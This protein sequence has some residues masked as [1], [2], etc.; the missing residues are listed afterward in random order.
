MN[1]IS[2]AITLATDTQI[3]SDAGTLFLGNTAT[4]SGGVNLTVA[5]DGNTTFNS[6]LTI[7]TLNKNGNGML[8]LNGGSTYG[9]G[10]FLNSG[11]LNFNNASA[12][13]TGPLVIAGGVIDNTSA[14]AIV[15]ALNNPQNWNADIT[16]LG[17]KD[18]NLGT[19]SVSMNGSRQVTVN[20][21]T[22]TVGGNIDGFG[23]SLT[24]LGPGT[25]VL[26]GSNTY[27]GGTIVSAGNLVFSGSSNASGVTV[28]A[29]TLRFQPTTSATVGAV[30]MTDGTKMTVASFNPNSTVVTATALNLGSLNGA[31][32]N[33][34]LVGNPTTAPLVATAFTTTGTGPNFNVIN[35]STSVGLT[36]GQFPLIS[37]A[38]TIGGNGFSGLTLGTLPL[39]VLASLVNNTANQRVDLNVTGTDTIRWNGTFSSTWDINTTL[40]WKTSST[41]SDTTYLQSSIPG[42]IV[43]FNDAAAA[44][45]NIVIPAPVNPNTVT[46]DNTTHD[47]TF[48]D[49]SITSVSLVK[50]GTG[51]LTFLNDNNFTNIAINAGH[52]VLGNGGT[53]GSLGT[54]SIVLASGATLTVNRSDAVTLGGFSGGGSLIKQGAGTL[55]LTGDYSG[56]T[57]TTTI[58]AGTVILQ[59]PTFTAAN[60]VT[61][62]AGATLDLGGALPADLLNLGAQVVT[63]VGAGVGGN[64]AAVNNGAAQQTNALQHLVLIGDTTIG[65][66]QRWDVRG[67]GSTVTGNFD[68]TKV[69]ANT[70]GFVNA[71][72]TIRDINVN[73]GTVSFSSATV[74]ARNINVNG[75]TL[76]IE[77]GSALDNSNAGT[78]TVNTGG[79]LAFAT[80]GGVDSTVN[81]PI[82]VNDMGVIG[83]TV[84]GTDGSSTVSA[85]ITLN[86][87]GV[88]NPLANA[89]LTLAGPITGTGTFNQ[90]GTGVTMLASTATISY[91]GNTTITAGTLRFGNTN[92][93]PSGTGAATIV[94][95][96]GTL[97][98]NGS[99]Q[100]IDGLTGT[101]VVDTIAG[102]APTLTI[103]GNNSSST[104]LGRYSK[105][106]RDAQSRQDGHRHTHACRHQYVHRHDD[107]QRGHRG[108]AKQ[109]RVRGRRGRRRHG[110]SRR[111]DRSRRHARRQRPEPWREDHQ[112][113]RRRLRRHWC[114]RQLQYAHQSNQRHSKTRFARRRLH[115]RHRAMGRSRRRRCHFRLRELHTH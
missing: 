9:G 112:H 19:G 29:G 20:A 92:Q 34:E 90:N 15:N 69:G 71:N 59:S 86:A 60:G 108:R 77:S 54:G 94:M 68:L 66:S 87:N 64:G 36:V 99:D 30:T 12:I 65:G 14:G 42:D 2:G 114:T 37:H 24:K 83:T 35:V 113:F 40:N 16:F 51:T 58:S 44:N 18:L 109:C 8:T 48:N 76:S 1:T 102:G 78:I 110:Q 31:I 26:G 49:A 79:T 41:S 75:G 84:G 100:V 81:K 72:V 4:I 93:L 107:D 85:P 28:N 67:F 63:I 43:T 21:G 74:A 10:T 11:Q 61:V 70:I 103:G 56:F 22:L 82:I 57:G 45:F 17:T 32:L 46:V 96:G 101:G 62:A 27:D 105:Y 115:R 5:G 88:F 33:F 95:T 6:V 104:F 55:T 7:A 98:L 97:D 23:L 106:G 47:Y 111:N 50:N 53:S 73:A 80:F 52:V 39:R 38:G 3:N 25:L 13:G 89:T 91:A